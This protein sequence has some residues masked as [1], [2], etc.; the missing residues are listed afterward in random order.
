MANRYWIGG[1]AAVAQVKTFTP[2]GTI[3]V[4]DIFNLIVVGERGETV[5]I[6]FAATAAT[7]ANVAAGLIAAWNASTNPLCTPVTASGT[8]TVILTAD[9]AG[10]PFYVTCTT[11]E[12]GGGAADDQT[13]TAVATVANSGPSDIN[14]AANWS[15]GVIPGASAGDVVYL[16]GAIILY[17]L[18]QLS[19]ANAIVL[20]ATASQAGANGSTGVPPTYLKYKLTEADINE[21]AGPGTPAYK[22]PFN[23]DSGTT[24]AVIRVHDSGV[25]SLST[26][27]S[28]NLLANNA[29]T[30]IYIFKGKVG[31][32]VHPGET[33][34]VS[35]I[36]W[37]GGNV[38]IGSGV[39]V[40]TLKHKAGDSA[41]NCAA[42]TIVQDGGT[43]QTNG[44]G[45]IGTLTTNGGTATL[46]SSGTITNLNADGGHADFTKSM[47]PRTVTNPK[48]GKNG[49]ISLDPSVVTR[50]NEI[51]PVE[52]SGNLAFT[53]QA[54]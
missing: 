47:T 25:N 43:L 48:L 14:T 11:T 27:P 19:I 40:A 33:A 32:A 1:A 16:D 28:I 41:V 37:M 34:T 42:T 54:A 20:H 3:E 44:S 35:E 29:A 50:A 23:L 15:D 22:S 49:K 7:A 4:G 30:K 21:N 18:D 26:E 38:Y 31:V 52:S 2:G 45:A 8:A 51:A 46:N 10:V 36:N 9:T 13:F 17:G 12:A 53:C 6:S 39:T 24:S 5:T